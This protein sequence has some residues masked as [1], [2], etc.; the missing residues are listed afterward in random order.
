MGET[1]SIGIIFH[2]VDTA[3]LFSIFVFLLKQHKMWVLIRDR[4]NMMYHQYC[5][6]HNIPFQGIN[7]AGY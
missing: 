6:D 1:G 3:L 7:G 4:V 2:S 5:K